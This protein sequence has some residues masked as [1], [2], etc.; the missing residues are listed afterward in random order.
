MLKHFWFDLLP[1]LYIININAFSKNSIL[2]ILCLIVSS[3]KVRT[4]FCSN[5][6]IFFFF[7]GILVSTFP[8]LRLISS[9]IL[10]FIW[11]PRCDDRWLSRKSLFLVNLIEDSIILLIFRKMLLLFLNLNTHSSLSDIS[12]KLYRYQFLISRKLLTIR[13]H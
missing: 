3:L 7:V 11:F 2:T 13:V 12:F 1:S 10:K 8:S 4:W 5:N 9:P 6:I